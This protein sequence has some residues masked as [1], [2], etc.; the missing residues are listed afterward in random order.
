[1]EGEIRKAGG[2]DEILELSKKG[3]GE[4]GGTKIVDFR[5]RAWWQ[6]NRECTRR[7]AKITH[8]YLAFLS[9]I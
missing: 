1:V 5:R 7:D 9:E 4:D 3:K 8:R 2:G 6:E